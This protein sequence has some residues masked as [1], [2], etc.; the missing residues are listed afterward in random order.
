MNNKLERFKKSVCGKHIILLGV[1][2]SN[3]PL[4]KQ[5]L[6]YGAEVTGCD[7]NAAM[8][9]EFLEEMKLGA[10]F[11]L[12]EDYL[13]DLKCDMIFKTPGIRPDIP[14][15]LEAE[16]KGVKV[17][18]EMEVFFK[19]CPCKIIAVTGSDG[20]TTTTTLIHNI[21]SQEGKICHLGGNIGKPLLPEIEKIETGDYAVVELSSFQLMSM[22]RSPDVAVVTNVAPNHLD[23]H[24]SMEEYVEAK[25]NIFRFQ[26]KSGLLVL[27]A[28]NEITKS[29]AEEA[30]GD[31]VFFGGSDG[32]VYEKDGK[33]FY[34]SK[35][36]MTKD[37]ILLP[38]E[39]N[40]ENYM[41]AIAAVGKRM[42]ADSIKQVARHFA[43]VEHRIEFVR[44][45]DG[46]KFYNDSI[47][48][49]PTRAKAAL[50]AFDRKVILIAGG[51]DKKIAF[52]E[53]GYDIK[54]K[55]KRLYLFGDTAPIIRDAVLKACEN[56]RRP[57]PIIMQYTTLE[58]IVKEAY[59]AAEA[60]DIVLLSPACAS[61]D[62]FKNFEERGKK[63]KEIVRRL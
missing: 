4:I 33:I 55:V 59:M 3:K 19:L 52:D 10:K 7:K 6:S 28:R 54:E 41:A 26:N 25:K 22:K 14:Q 44:E 62:M 23:V 48:S 40:V 32:G 35:N 37:D 29:F 17:T 61:F 51:Y 53:F 2:I 39:H 31:V 12:G 16:R 60:G 57:F 58:S 36:V 63:F 1:G 49:S 27:N 30:R 42:S 21:L 34:D 24:K 46:V 9:D 15:L 50:N 20:K 45:V 56:G 43:G 47:A 13:D 18:S 5:L 8:K 38:G 11:R